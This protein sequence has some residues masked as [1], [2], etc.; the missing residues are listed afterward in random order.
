MFLAFPKLHGPM[1]AH[2][3]RSMVRDPVDSSAV[4]F[5]ADVT[6]AKVS[7]CSQATLKKTKL[8]VSAPG[9]HTTARAFQAG[10]TL[11]S[12]CRGGDVLCLATSSAQA[13]FVEVLLPREVL[14]PGQ[15]EAEESSARV[16]MTGVEAVV[17]AESLNTFRKLHVCGDLT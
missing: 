12:Q 16:A 17:S 10:S 3:P 4:Y 14:L 7:D 15:L 2:A 13:F 8:C 1:Q 11:S 9:R 6:R 5:I